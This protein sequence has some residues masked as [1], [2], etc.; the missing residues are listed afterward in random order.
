MASAAYIIHFAVGNAK[1]VSKSPF[2]GIYGIKISVGC[3]TRGFR[4]LQD[5]Y[6]GVLFAHFLLCLPAEKRLALVVCRLLLF[7]SDLGAHLFSAA[8]RTWTLFFR[9]N[10][11]FH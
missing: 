9:R 3:S 11:V 6:F 7:K 8:S 10:G 1:L 2:K 5:G 4:L